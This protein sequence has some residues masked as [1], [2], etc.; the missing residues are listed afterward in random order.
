MRNTAWQLILQE[1][2]VYLMQND[3]V[4]TLKPELAGQPVWEKRCIPAPPSTPWITR[5]Y[6][7]WKKK[8]Q[9]CQKFTPSPSDGPVMTVKS[10]RIEKALKDREKGHAST[11][12]RTDYSHMI[13]LQLIQAICEED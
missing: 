1:N 7:S 9:N 3:N 10:T 8:K 2:F 11:S 4:G 5:T 6:Q 13:D 12:S